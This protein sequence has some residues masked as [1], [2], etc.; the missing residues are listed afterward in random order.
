MSYFLLVDCN[1]FY[2]SCERLFNPELEGKPVIVLSN[3]DG[4][5]VARSQEAKKLGIQMGEPFFK[6][7]GLC[8]HSKVRVY[9]SN[10]QLYGDISQRIMQVLHQL[11][12][13]IEVYSIDEAFL[14]YPN[15]LSQE[16]IF[17]AS[18]EIRQLIKKWIGMP[19]S[20]GIAPSKTLAKV[21]NDI[22]KQD[23][24]GIVDLSS[25]ERREL[26]LKKFAIGDVWGVGSKTQSKLRSVG[27]CTAWQFREMDPS[28]VR[29]Q[30]GVVG[31]RMLWELRGVSCLELEKIQPKKSL[32]YS[33]SF[34]KS[35]GDLATLAEALSTYV[36]NACVK[37]RKQKSSAQAL[38]VFLETH[39][40]PETKTRQSYSTVVMLD[41]PTNDTPQII[42]AAKRCLMKLFREN[43]LYK[44]CG[45]TLLDLIPEAVVMPDF[46]FGGFNK[47]RQDLAETVDSLNARF[48][49]NT[50]F[51]A[52]MGVS[53]DWKL[54][55]EKRSRQYTTCWSDLASAQAC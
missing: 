46:L 31:E 2:V 53:A 24:T 4:C 29:R 34:G 35:I 41:F 6:I 47:K 20:I 19:V 12:P 21:A 52:A 22:A 44:K 9:S 50:L 45:V 37:L 15:T 14:K 36:A 30:F 39:F 3:N 11:A 17:K 27:V 10:Y 5:V 51:Y 16:D 42:C 38:H 7:K 33:R 55:C 54:N 48:G 13:E 28:N 32:C 23:P 1:N 43:E 26:I 40:D 25:S 18:V 49:K 8:K